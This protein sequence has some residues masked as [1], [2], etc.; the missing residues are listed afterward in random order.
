MTNVLHVNEG[1]KHEF[2]VERPGFLYPQQH[3]ISNEVLTGVTIKIAV[4]Q[5]VLHFCC[6][7]CTI[8]LRT[9]P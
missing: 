3:F 2:S 4:A 9:A 5:G 1:I 6:Q 7:A 8:D